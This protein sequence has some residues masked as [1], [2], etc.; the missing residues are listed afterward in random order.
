MPPCGAA[1]KVTGG[2]DPQ[3][4]ACPAGL[5]RIACD[6]EEQ[7]GD[8]GR[9]AGGILTRFNLATLMIL[10]A[11]SLLAQAGDEPTVF[12]SKYAG[13]TPGDLAD[14]AAG[15]PAARIL[16]PGA[17]NEVVPFG[18]IRVAVP[19]E[20]FIERYKDIAAFKKGKEVLQI[21]KFHSPPRLED[22]DGLTLDPDELETLKL[23]RVGD[24]G[25]KM[26]AEMIEQIHRE[27]N[28]TAP[29]WQLLA[30][31]AYRRLLFDY[32][33]GYLQKGQLALAVYRD[34]PEPLRLADELQSILQAS[35]YFMQYLPDMYR[36]LIS[37][38]DARLPESEDFLYWS[39][40]K[41]GF[42]P[43]VSVTHV[44]I[45]RIACGSAVAYVIASKQIYADHYFIGSL[46]STAIIDK[47][48]RRPGT[49]AYLMYLNRTRVDLLQGLFSGLKRFFIKR[50]LLDGMD[51]YLRLVKQRLED[52]YRSSTGSQGIPRR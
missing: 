15:N 32:V 30:M 44:T 1:P 52:E 4:G 16:A 6:S 10:I 45:C 39:Q 37:F 17:S 13:F 12:L 31:I 23:C 42:K 29:D 46:G 28:W 3:A 2:S 38:P 41:F 47:D 51:K 43:V 50:R 8:L 7:S 19:A 34:K 24:C 11:P 5:K 33:N 26:T 35:P 49:E 21:G 14:L 25:L 27:V 20:F 22:L 40:E 48:R 36:Y 9:I 18:V